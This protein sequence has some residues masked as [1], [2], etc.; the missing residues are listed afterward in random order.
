MT[1]ASDEEFLGKTL[2]ERRSLVQNWLTLHDF[3]AE[4]ADLYRVRKNAPSSLKM[5][6]AVASIMREIISLSRRY[7]PGSDK[8]PALSEFEYWLAHVDY[9]QLKSRRFRNL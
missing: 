9:A 1:S 8:L 4:T 6:H 2:E 3:N 7:S 5:C